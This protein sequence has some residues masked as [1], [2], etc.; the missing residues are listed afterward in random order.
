MKTQENK[1]KILKLTQLGILIALVVVL[2]SV[3]S[4]GFINI[5]L[6]LIPITLGAILLD[7]KGGLV[8]GALFGFIALFWGI[9][10]K[11]QFTFFLFSANPAMTIAICLV[12]GS[13]AGLVPA[14]L[15]KWLSKYNYKN[16]KLVA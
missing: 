5:C 4:F 14:F 15:Y 13:L 2:Q 12:K 11:D 8:L 3:A 7:W 10:G 9:L 1:Q 16:N 6:C